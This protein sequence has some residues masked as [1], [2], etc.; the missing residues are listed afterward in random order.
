VSGNPRSILL[1]VSLKGVK[2]IKTFK[3]I[4]ASSQNVIRKQQSVTGMCATTGSRAT[5][6]TKPIFVKNTALQ[7]D[8]S[9]TGSSKGSVS[10]ETGDDSDSQY[11]RLQ[12]TRKNDHH[13]C[14][15]FEEVEDDSV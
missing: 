3:I 13:R 15:G 14:Y 1:P 8:L 11:P 9:S 6:Q 4:N 12:L 10:E 7:D 2:D 5:L